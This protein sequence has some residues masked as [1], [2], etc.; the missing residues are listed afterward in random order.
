MQLSLGVGCHLLEQRHGG[1][2]F[3]FLCDHYQHLIAQ[4]V[5]WLLFQ[6]GLYAILGLLA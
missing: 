4:A 5:G 6:N 2:A 1:F 3:L